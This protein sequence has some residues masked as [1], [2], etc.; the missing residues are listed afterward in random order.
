MRSSH[1]AASATLVFLHLL[2]VADQITIAA[3]V[4]TPELIS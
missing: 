4:S 1:A 3:T 2:A